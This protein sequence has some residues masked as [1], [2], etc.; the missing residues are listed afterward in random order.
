[1]RT[2]QKISFAV[3][4]TAML[5]FLVACS[6]SLTTNT[7]SDEEVLLTA[8]AANPLPT[9][10][11]DQN[12]AIVKSKACQVSS[13]VSVQVDKA[14]GD[15]IAWSPTG[16][17]LAYVTPSNEKWGWFVG[18]LVILDVPNQ[19]AIYTSQDLEVQGDL[20]WSP[21]GKKL[22]FTVL[23]PTNQVYTIDVLEVESGTL[24][25]VF[26]SD[27]AKTDD[28]SSPKG[29][30]KWLDTAIV[31]VTSSCDV[32]CSRYYD[33]NTSTTQMTIG[34][35]TRKA[36]D[37]SLQ[38]TNEY[39]SPDSKWQLTT[40]INDNTWISSASDHQ[41]SILISATTVNEIKW[42]G[43]SSYLAVRTDDTIFLYEPVCKK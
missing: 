30:D 35:E 36:E 27:A 14:Q 5:G 12:L 13:L 17:Y 41:A 43:D 19:K 29:I 33:F 37:T 26:S 3:L 31:Q 32:D 9:Q 7:T 24:Q 40:D 16:N 28:W 42:S 18:S 38:I 10:L 23:D 8:Q 4:I 15:M 2:I 34:E 6:S 25:Q 1:M 21:D 22:A 20:T 39:T 11:A